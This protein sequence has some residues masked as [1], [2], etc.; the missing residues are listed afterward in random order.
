MVDIE[1][2]RVPI[3]RL[4]ATVDPATLTFDCT[5]E[6]Q[7]LTGFVGQERAIRSLQFGLDIRRPG[8]NIFVT[9]LTGTGKTTAILEYIRRQIATQQNHAMVFDW[10][11]VHN[12]DYPDAPN[13]IALPP[14]TG[15][16]MRQDL[17]NLLEAIRGNLT[18]VFTSPDYERQRR[19]VVEQG[20]A[21]GQSIMDAAGQRALAAGFALSFSPMGANLV[22]LKDGKALTPEE[23]QGLTQEDRAAIGERERPLGNI[24]NEVGEQ[25]HAV[26]REVTAAVHAL[27]RQV[28][29]AI[30]RAPFADIEK[31]YSQ[32]PEVAQFLAQLLKF[33]LESADFLRQLA[34]SPEAP[35][36]PGTALASGPPVDPF[37]AFRVNVLVDN[38]GAITPPIVFEQNPTWSNLFGRIDRRAYLGTYLS[39]HTMLKP[40][41]VH[42]ANGGY[43]VLNFIDLVT[44][45]GAWDGLKRVIKTSEVRM[46]DPM[47]QYGFMPPQGLRPEPVPVDVKLVVTG[48][49]FAY[50]ILSANDEEF[51]ELFKVKA[52][53][54]SEIAFTPENVQ[55]YAAFVCT[56]CE[57]AGLRHFDRSAVAALA[58]W[59]RRLA[60]DQLKLSARFGR[61]RDV[62]IEADYWAGQENAKR[63]MAEHVRKAI[64]EKAYR[65][66]LIQERVAEMIRRGIIIIDTDGAVVGQVNALAVLEIGDLRFGRPSRITARTYLGQR[67]VVSI[68]RESQLSGRIHDKG[69]LILTGYLGSQY[70]QSRPLALSAT[71][72]F[73]Q[74]YDM[75]DG[76]SA[77]L[78]ETC[79]IL[80]S[81]AGLPL[82]QDIAITGSVNQKGEV[83][84][85]GGVNDKVEGFHDVCAVAGF[86]GSQGVIVPARSVMQ[87]M[88]REDVLQSV[89]DGKFGVY[90]VNSIDEAIEVLTGVAAGVPGADGTYPEGTVHYLVS[91][92]LDEMSESIRRAPPSGAPTVVAGGPP[93]ETP[94]RPPEIPK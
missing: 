52:D 91:K 76:D 78:A 87:L 37:L 58:E 15:H 83:Q 93:P 12:F 7:P 53:F 38:S 2:R 60:E 9:G 64:S 18:R 65:T 88:L 11:Y 33:T 27:D 25:L 44:R 79:A 46:D 20:Q 3:E 81:L 68:D 92:K 34:V 5:D 63:I 40:G 82:R 4:R 26:E 47:E 51:W 22:P 84:P 14:G 73:E 36:I 48:D 77:S 35:T 31:S 70:G 57:R 29:E 80:S 56:V 24:I 75:V 30:V 6:L 39:D 59:G 41:A 90:E 42:R 62:I 86:T 28:V 21:R 19:Q 16:R 8:Y 50:Y 17:D 49:P 61:L 23:F 85:V 43:L 13:A 89:R 54:D 72:S 32:F 71:I 67:G 74:G 45:P 55:A 69:V 10:C 94:P 1:Q 66:N